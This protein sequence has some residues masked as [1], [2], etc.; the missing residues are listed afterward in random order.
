VPRQGRREDEERERRL[1]LLKFLGLSEVLEPGPPEE[2]VDELLAVT[3][4]PGLGRAFKCRVCGALFV[5]RD[6][7]ERHRLSPDR[8][9]GAKRVG[10]SAGGGRGG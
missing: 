2:V 1:T 10:L 7:F 6:D 3:E 9:C 8:G 4:L 5:S